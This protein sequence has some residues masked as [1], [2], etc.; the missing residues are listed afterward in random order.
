MTYNRAMQHYRNVGAQS[1]VADADPHQLIRLLFTA[2]M[3]RLAAAKGHMGRGEVAQKGEQIGRVISIVET[4]RASLDHSAGAGIAANLDDL[5]GYMA[6]RLLQANLHNN[7]GYLD[8]VAGL[9]REI[10][11]A[12]EAIPVEVRTPERAPQRQQAAIG[13]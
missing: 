12:W 3:D 1:S 9:L 5:Y 11:D 6:R 8:E 7:A 13:V 2:A 4:L 10:K